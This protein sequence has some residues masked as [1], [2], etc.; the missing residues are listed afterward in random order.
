M[1]Q[2]TTFHDLAH[3]AQTWGLVL[4]L[5]AFAAI[6][7]YAF[8]PGNRRKFKRAAQIPLDDEKSA[9]PAGKAE[10]AGEGRD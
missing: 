3:F 6:V 9:P 2:S 8:W 4:F 5:I 1:S 10:S 7:A